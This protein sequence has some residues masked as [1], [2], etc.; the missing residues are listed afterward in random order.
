MAGQLSREDLTFIKELRKAGVLQNVEGHRLD[1][2]NGIISVNCADGDRFYDIVQYQAK[3]QAGQRLDLDPRIHSLSWHGGAL[4]CAPD[5]PVNKR[6]L[7]YEVFLDQ[8]TDARAIKD[9]NVVALGAHG[10]CGAAALCGINLPRSIRLHVR[11]KTKIKM[12]NKGI[13]VACF[14]HVDYGN[15][16]KRTYFLSRERWEKWM[17]RSRSLRILAELYC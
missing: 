16:K 2:R 7:A 9:I 17:K 3:M 11:A 14:F 4:A 15:D 5:S 8:I 6:K 1:Q 13:E 12:L 10:P